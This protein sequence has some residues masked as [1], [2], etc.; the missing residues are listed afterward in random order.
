MISLLGAFSNALNALHSLILY[1]TTTSMAAST[2]IGI[3]LAKGIKISIVANKV[4]ACTIP[5]IGLFP[6]DFT[7]AAVLA[8][9][10]VAGIPPNNPDVILARPWATSSIFESCVSE[11]IPSATTADN[12]DSRAAK[13]AIVIAGVNNLFIVLIFKD[14]KAGA[15]IA[16]EISLNLLPIVSTGILNTLTTTVAQINAIIDPGIV[17]LTLGQRAI[18]TMQPTPIAKDHIFRVFILEKYDS[19]LGKNSA[20]T[21]SICSPNKS[22]T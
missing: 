12:N 18:I 20:G 16:D 3:I 8:I 21:L 14:G 22:F 15:G 10:P 4:I 6:P 1:D 13:I 17:L 11:I 19:H 9:A 7:L 5:E 2:V